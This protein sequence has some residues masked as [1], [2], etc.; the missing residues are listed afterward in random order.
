MRNQ[1]SNVKYPQELIKWISKV[2]EK[3]ASRNSTL[4][5]EQM[6]NIFRKTISQ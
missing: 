2:Y 1:T 4:N 5:F 3:N 6:T